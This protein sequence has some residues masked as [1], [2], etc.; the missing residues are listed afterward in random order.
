MPNHMHGILFITPVG[1]TH[2]LPKIPR[3]SPRPAGSKQRS[4]GTIVGSFKS[5]VTKRVNALRSTPGV[6]IW[7]RNYYEHVVRDDEDLRELREYIV[8]NPLRWESDQLH[9]DNPSKW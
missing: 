3:I 5:A 7:Q 8:N 6:S 4:L 9:P 1:A 2:A